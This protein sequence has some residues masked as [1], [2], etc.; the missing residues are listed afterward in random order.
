MHAFLKFGSF[1]KLSSRVHSN[2]S[3]IYLVNLL[4]IRTSF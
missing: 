3:H 4:C 2:I 1:N